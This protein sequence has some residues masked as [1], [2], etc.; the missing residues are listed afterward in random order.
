M[1]KP[2]FLFRFL[3]SWSKAL[4]LKRVVVIALNAFTY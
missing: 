4:R 2:V 3:E 1:L